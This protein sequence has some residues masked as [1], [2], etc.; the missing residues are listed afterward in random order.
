M[1]M[2]KGLGYHVVCEGVETRK[3]AE[4]LLEIGCQEAQGFLFYRPMPME[5][6]EKLVYGEAAVWGRGSD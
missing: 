4:V 5:E 3:Q 2:I 6:Y 1:G